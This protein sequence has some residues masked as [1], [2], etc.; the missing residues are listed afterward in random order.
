[1]FSQKLTVSLCDS[2]KATDMWNKVKPWK[3]IDDIKENQSSFRV[4]K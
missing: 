1:M 3:E 4:E 2:R